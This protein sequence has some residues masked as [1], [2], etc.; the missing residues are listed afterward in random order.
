[1]VL[2]SAILALLKIVEFVG[3]AVLY[4]ITSGAWGS[5][6]VKSSLVV[7]GIAGLLALFFLY[8]S[9]E[10]IFPF[11]KIDTWIS[12][13]FVTGD[14]SHVVTTSGP[15]PPPKNKGAPVPED[16]ISV[17]RA[18]CQSISVSDSISL[19]REYLQHYPNGLCAELAKAR[20]KA[21]SEPPLPTKPL[22]DA[23]KALTKPIVRPAHSHGPSKV[24]K[25]C[26]VL[27]TGERYCD[28]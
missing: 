11:P 12:R 14:D 9:L 2:L 7:R 22:A 27:F 23:S 8:L 1:M 13:W 25:N 3:S 5:E 6:K 10:A 17:E 16:Q 24:D 15:K 4:L 19:Y 20:V 21:L 18:Y 26:V 28:H